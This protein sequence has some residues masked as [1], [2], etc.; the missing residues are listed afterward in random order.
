MTFPLKNNIPYDQINNGAL[1]ILLL[2][3][4]RTW[5]ELCRRYAH[6]QH[7]DLQHNTTSMELYKKLR[8]LKEAGLIDFEEQTEGEKK[9]LGKVWDT[10]LWPTIRV[11]FGGMSLADAAL[12]SRHSIG[13]AVTPLFR[14]PAELAEPLDVFVLMPF[15][16]ALGRVYRENIK[17]LGGELGVTIMRGDEI[18]T[19][20]PGSFM[21][22]VWSGICS[23]HLIIADC[24]RA[25]PN[26]FYE[27]GIAHTL[28]KPVVLITRSGEAV[29]SDIQHIDHIE[30]SEDVAGITFLVDRL[31]EF[32]VRKLGSREAREADK[33]LKE[34]SVED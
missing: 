32:I 24:T 34:F 22:K 14:R 6:T 2:R 27:I 30:F 7:D 31:R 10:G 8:E 33:K 21:E 17:P 5:Q 16:T 19:P 13:M 20:M 11:A 26:V 25:N 4:C 23:A 18:F 29:P 9:I 28:G 1:I 12:L 15:D 3:E